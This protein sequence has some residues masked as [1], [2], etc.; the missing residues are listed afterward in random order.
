MVGIWEQI[1]GIFE[2]FMRGIC[3]GKE[4]KVQKSTFFLFAVKASVG[5]GLAVFDRGE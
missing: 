5:A 4:E 3:S 1:R 2:S